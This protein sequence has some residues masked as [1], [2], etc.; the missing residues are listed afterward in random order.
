MKTYAILLCEHTSRGYRPIITTEVVGEI[1]PLGEAS[2]IVMECANQVRDG[3]EVANGH[4]HVEVQGE[5]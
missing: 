1:K 5:G 2:L 4:V 3:A